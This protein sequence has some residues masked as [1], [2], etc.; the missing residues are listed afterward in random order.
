MKI[1]DDEGTVGVVYGVK[2]VGNVVGMSEDSK[3]RLSFPLKEEVVEESLEAQDGERTKKGI[4]TLR[5]VVNGVCTVWRRGG[6]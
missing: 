1:T 2:R 3:R 4:E 6:C 5:G